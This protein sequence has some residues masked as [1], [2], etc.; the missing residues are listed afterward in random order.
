MPR[1][2]DPVPRLLVILA[3][4]ETYQPETAVEARPYY[5]PTVGVPQAAEILRVHPKTILDLIAECR[6]P[7]GKVG[8][9]YLMMTKDVLAYADA[10]IVKETAGR[11][12]APLGSAIPRKRRVWPK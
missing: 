9:S 10:V 11:M 2:N 1:R 7:A 6:I 3:D 12:R 4:Q 8:R 5:G